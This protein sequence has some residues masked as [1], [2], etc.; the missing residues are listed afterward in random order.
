GRSDRPAAVTDYDV[1]HLTDDLVGLLDVLGL[2]RAVFCGHD[3]GGII[4]WRMAM[5]HP[6]RVAGV[7]ALN[8]PFQ[9]R[10]QR[11]LITT[12]RHVFGDQHYM[13]A[14]Q[15][16]Q[17]P[18]A[19]FEQDV[20]RVLGR[21]FRKPRSG[22]A[23]NLP[24][25]QAAR[26]LTLD[27]LTGSGPSGGTPFLPP[28]EFQVYVDTFRATGFG[29]GIN[30]YRNMRRNWELMESVRQQVDAPAL[31]ISAEHDL[32]L[33]PRL[34][35]GMERWVPKVERQTIRDCGHWTQQEQPDQVNALMIDWLH[36]WFRPVRGLELR[37]G[38][39]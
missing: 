30:W 17:V 5:L 8:T 38:R 27:A 36:R 11:D 39:R 9:A 21:M 16:P 22:N 35:D 4:V 26:M 29:G 1:I 3:W 25:D 37:R 31:M 6:D 10:G 23:V 32:F 12:L 19:M 18:E 20:A 34:T 28:E 24:P 7:I 14:F 33:P 2:E 13:V 15:Q